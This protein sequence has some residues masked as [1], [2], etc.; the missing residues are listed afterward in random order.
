MSRGLFLG[1]VWLGLIPTLVIF[2][3]LGPRRRAWI[4]PLAWWLSIAIG[5][6]MLIY[7]DVHSTAPSFGKRVTLEGKLYDFVERGTRD[8][9]FAFHFQPVTGKPI[10]METQIFF[11]HWGDPSIAAQRTFRVVYIQD[12]NLTLHNEA[13][14]IEILAGPD[15]GFHD[16]LDSRP[17]G[18]WL[19]IP[20]GAILVSFGVLGL[21]YMKADAAAAMQD[22][23]DS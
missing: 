8:S 20:F 5:L 13:V 22:D 3:A 16:S 14:D 21:K 2:F 9:Y 1:C 17:T 19:F 15:A 10:G 4:P 7:G 6:L 11:P 23:S 18:A 12:G